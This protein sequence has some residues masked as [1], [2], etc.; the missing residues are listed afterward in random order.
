LPEIDPKFARRGLILVF[1][2][3]LLDIIG[4]AMI[5]P[6]MPKFLIDLTGADVSQAGFD[7][8]ILLAVY[9]GMQFLFAPFIGNLSDRFGRRPILLDLLNV[10]NWGLDL[11]F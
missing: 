10:Q 8:G 2:T 7:G 1:I 5:A 6:V 3:L 4:I 9:A 11:S